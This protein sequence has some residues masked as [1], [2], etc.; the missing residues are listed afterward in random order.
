MKG[1]ITRIERRDPSLPSLVPEAEWN[2][3]DPTRTEVPEYASYEIVFG[4]E[5]KQELVDGVEVLRLW[6]NAK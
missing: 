5:E 3:P 4:D 2:V 1:E 6:A